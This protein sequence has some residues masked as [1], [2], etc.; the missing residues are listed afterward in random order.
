MLTDTERSHIERI[1]LR[2]RERVTDSMTQ[3]EGEAQTALTESGELTLYD[4]HPA[5]IGTETYEQEQK[6]MLAEQMS[7]RQE[8]IDEALRRLRNEPKSFGTCERCGKPIG[9]E[10]LEVIPEGRFCAECQGS[11]ERETAGAGV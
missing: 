3:M 11:I 8:E 9:T 2:E 7:R 1:L 10:R 5:D 6:M 4:Q